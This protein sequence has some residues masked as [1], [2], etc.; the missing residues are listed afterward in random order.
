MSVAKTDINYVTLRHCRWVEGGHSLVQSS[1]GNDR[2][3]NN[4][5]N[6]H[7]VIHTWHKDRNVKFSM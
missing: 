7:E 2:A 4:N 3:D 6:M 1:M 5:R